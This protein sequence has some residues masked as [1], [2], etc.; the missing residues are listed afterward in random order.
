MF[1]YAAELEVV[2]WFVD[3]LLTRHYKL[4]HPTERKPRARLHSGNGDGSNLS[5]F[6]RRF[7]PSELIRNFTVLYSSCTPRDLPARFQDEMTT[8]V[9]SLVNR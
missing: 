2:S 6:L 9:I 1:I 7:L 5:E 4:Q 8:T 3:V